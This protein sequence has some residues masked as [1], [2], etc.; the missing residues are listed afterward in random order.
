MATVLLLVANIWYFLTRSW[1]STFYPTSYATIYY[2]TD[3]PVVTS[4]QEADGG[5]EAV[6]KWN[7]PVEGWKLY[8]NGELV[9]ENSGAAIYFPV[10]EDYS[11]NRTYTVQALPENLFP[12]FEMKVRYL[13]D[14]F[15]TD[16]GLSRG[17]YA[18][19]MSDEPMAKFKQFAVSDW[20]DR[21]EYL[22]ESDLAEVEAILREEAGIQDSDTSLEKLEKV[23]M[24]QRDNLTQT[25][26]GTPPPQYRWESPYTIYKE[27]RAG[28][29]HGWCTQHA[30][31]FTFLANR[32]G[33]ST[34][35]VVTARTQGN[36][37]VYTGH[38]WVEA[39]IPEQG[40][41]AWVEPSYAV[42]YATDKKGQV[43]NSVE[44]ANLRQ[45]AAWDGVSGRVYK[46]WGWP[47]LSGEANTLIDAP[48]PDVGGVVERQFITS[49]IY[50]WRR[51]PNVEDLRYDYRMLFK[52][53]TFTWGNF[54][55]YYFKPPLAYANYPTEGT[56]TY[57]IRHLLLWSFL[58]CAAGG[59]LLSFRKKR[60]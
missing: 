53:W 13:S 30:Q 17:W 16:R 35:L 11:D 32:A 12:P 38:T 45:H 23:M 19:V 54:V 2:P 29:G 48:F 5:V 47:E 1:E 3:R 34:R 40:R 21:Y 15:N 41:W 44:L 56:R 33:L 52:D 6:V 28:T 9:S 50:K 18:I 10:D 31:V 26:R 14:E 57:W 8:F 60:S 42:I 4:W 20:V 37:F 43:L 7:A 55:R 49:A 51:P 27:M 22:P 36:K 39:W 58:A 59:A 25:C 24:H 46:D